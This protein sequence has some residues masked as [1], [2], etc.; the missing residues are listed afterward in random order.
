M[1]KEVSV[2]IYKS[3][4]S[5]TLAAGLAL[6][7]AVAAAQLPS[8][9]AADGPRFWNGGIG[10]EEVLAMRGQAYAFP[11]RLVFSDGPRNEFTANVPV[12]IYDERGN[13]VFALPD[14]GPMLYVTLPEGRYTVT[15][16]VDGIAKT[17]RVTV[18]G[19][20]GRDVV[21][22]WNSDAESLPRG[23]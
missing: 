21:F 8:V 17:Q 23:M 22:H 16:Q 9:M 20:Q 6:S 3:V 1:R 18:A 5:A 13:A 4:G 7:S 15:A 19:G 10:E 2:R 12:V 11:L 14:A